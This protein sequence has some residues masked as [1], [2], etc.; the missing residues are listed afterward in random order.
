[1]AVHK[2]KNGFERWRE[3]SIDMRYRTWKN[4]VDVCWE[5]GLVNSTF[6]TIWRN[7]TKIISAFEQ[8]GSSVERF[9]SR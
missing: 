7:V 9:E 6:Q 8:N 5:L 1:M 2:Q 4:K 3:I